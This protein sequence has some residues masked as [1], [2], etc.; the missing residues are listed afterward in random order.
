MD[1]SFDSNALSRVI[2]QLYVN[3]KGRFAFNFLDDLIVY[4]GTMLEHVPHLREMLARLQGAGYKIIPGKVNIGD[5]EIKYLVHVF[6]S[7]GFQVMP[8]STTVI[9]NYLRPPNLRALRRL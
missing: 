6:C 2:H 5:R 3:L 1:I 4:F 8:E 9:R 7:E